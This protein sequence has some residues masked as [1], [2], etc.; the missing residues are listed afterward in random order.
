MFSKRSRKIA[1][2]RVGIPGYRHEISGRRAFHNLLGELPQLLRVDAHM[3]RST[4]I[5]P[6]C[7]PVQFGHHRVF[8]TRAKKLIAGSKDFRS[9]ESRDIIHDRPRSGSLTDISSDAVSASLQRYH[10]DAFRGLIGNG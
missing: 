4:D 5:E 6:H 10:V 3:K 2:H 8:E 7:D 9:D 1:K